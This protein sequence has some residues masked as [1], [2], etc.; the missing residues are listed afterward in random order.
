M[1]SDLRLFL[2]L[3]PKLEK[4]GFKTD[5]NNDNICVSSSSGFFQCFMSLSE[6][7]AGARAILYMKELEHDNRESEK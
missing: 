4:L 5:V 3:N 2:D 7:N 6:Y 1:I